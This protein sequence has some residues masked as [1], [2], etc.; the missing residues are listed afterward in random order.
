MR[1]S[2]VWEGGCAV[3]NLVAQAGRIAVR[4]QALA[5]AEVEHVIRH[6]QQTLGYSFAVTIRSVDSIPHS[7]SGKFED[8]ICELPQ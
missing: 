6:M 7:R 2:A 3:D 8:S 1:P 5:S 4:H